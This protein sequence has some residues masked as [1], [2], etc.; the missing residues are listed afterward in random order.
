M[1]REFLT[2]TFILL[3]LQVLQMVFPREKFSSSLKDIKQDVIWFLINEIGMTFVI[4]KVTFFL[5]SYFNSVF[6][7]MI[8]TIN[9]SQL[10]FLPQICLF[11]LILDFISYWS[12]RIQHSTRLWEIHKLH[13]SVKSL[14]PFSSFRHSFLENIYNSSIVIILTSFISL[15]PEVRNYGVMIFTYVCVIQ[16]TNIKVHIPQIFKK[17]FITPDCHVT[18]HSKTNFVKYG[19]NFGFIFSIWDQL[20]RTYQDKEY[21][22]L[23]IGIEEDPF[24]GNIAK[25]FLYPIFR[26]K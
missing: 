9:L 10:S 18:H 2:I 19:Q 20:F 8:G 5:S 14:S 17:L 1:L 16:H 11:I 13:H 23:T 24:K 26:S 12:H 6:A 7:P 21:S 15:S 4:V 25:D 3:G 22:E